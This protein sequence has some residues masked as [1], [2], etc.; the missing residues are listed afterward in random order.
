MSGIGHEQTL[1]GSLVSNNRW[2]GREALGVGA[3]GPGRY[4][5]RAMPVRPGRPPLSFTVRYR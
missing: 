2:R 5:R 4:C 1:T 3:A